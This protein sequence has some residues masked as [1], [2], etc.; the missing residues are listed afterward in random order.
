M[1]SSLVCRRSLKIIEK[2]FMMAAIQ[3]TNEARVPIEV[4][5]GN[6]IIASESLRDVEH[7]SASSTAARRPGSL[8][9]I[10]GC[11]STR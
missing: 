10:I 7:G 1:S 11:V 4:E 5:K 3:S 6:K 2:K 9:T 8:W